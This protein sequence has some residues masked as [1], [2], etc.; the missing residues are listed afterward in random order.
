V[1]DELRARIDDLEAQLQALKA[2]LD[3]DDRVTT[4]RG[5]LRAAAAAGIA[6]VVGATATSR[7]AAAATGGN[8]VLG[9]SNTADTVTALRNDGPFPSLTGPGPIALRLESP[10]AHLQFVGAPGDAVFGT[11][12][13][14]TLAYNGGAGL[15]L[16]SNDTVVRVADGTTSPIHLLPAPERIYDSRR[17]ETL[18]ASGVGPMASGEDRQVNLGFSLGVGNDL[19]NF[20][21]AG[22]MINVTIVSTVGSGYLSVGPPALSA[23]PSSNVN[24]TAPGQV[25][26]NMAITALNEGSLQLWV[27]GGGAAHVIIDVMS[28]LG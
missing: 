21:S 1:T 22:A 24:W 17:P 25:V 5:M 3:N 12:P 23:P 28:I 26:A 10:G 2:E 18:G 6:G 8:L 7:P 14:G 4:R 11:Y 20:A 16:W 13:N 9:Q 15:L 27:G 19:L